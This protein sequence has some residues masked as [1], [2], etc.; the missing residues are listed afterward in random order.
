MTK[1][2][3]IVT[4]I[5]LGIQLLWFPVSADEPDLF[6]NMPPLTTNSL[7]KIPLDEALARR[8]HLPMPLTQLQTIL[9]A[10]GEPAKPPIMGD[11]TSVAPGCDAEYRWYH[12]TPTRMSYGDVYVVKGQIISL[13]FEDD[14]KNIV[15]RP[16][17]QLLIDG[18][19]ARP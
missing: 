6:V 17:G 15:K 11:C 8:M 2:I 7:T 12:Y 13:W 4:G 5:C 18:K 3:L 10:K 1:W 9:G 14:G 16:N 19:F